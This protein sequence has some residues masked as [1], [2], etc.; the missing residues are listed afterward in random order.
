[1]PHVSGQNGHP[2]VITTAELSARQRSEQMDATVEQVRALTTEV[3]SLRAQMKS[4][5]DRLSDAR[6][7][8]E[9]I[10][11]AF[12]RRV[13]DI[14]SHRSRQTASFMARLRWLFTGR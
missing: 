5:R 11:A 14:E 2:R 8:S 4:L 12:E 13:S 9:R 6:D 1:M 3:L 7:D 10:D